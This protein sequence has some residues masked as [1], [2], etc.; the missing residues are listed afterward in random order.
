MA[1]PAPSP[2]PASPLAS[3]GWGQ[4]WEIRLGQPGVL[5]AERGW[6]GEGAGTRGLGG[7]WGS[8]AGVGQKS[9]PREPGASCTEAAPVVFWAGVDICKM[10]ALAKFI[11]LG[12]SSSLPPSD[13]LAYS[14][15]D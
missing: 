12:P 15:E 7:V 2:V 9:R 8:G 5:G 1:F 13:K 14:A 6:V 11:S 10:G 4:L 3:P